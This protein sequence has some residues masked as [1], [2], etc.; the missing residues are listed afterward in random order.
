MA[1]RRDSEA[2]SSRDASERD[3]RWLVNRISRYVEKGINSEDGEVTVV[4]Q[5]MFERYYGEL[6][7]NEREGYSKYVS[8]EVFKAIEWGLP[9]LLRVF[10]GGVKAVEFKATGPDDVEQAK[11]ETDIVNHWF[12]DGSDEESGFMVLYSWLKDIMLYPNGYVRVRVEERDEDEVTELEGLTRDE[13]NA[14]REG[15]DEADI[16]PA[17]THDGRFDVTVRKTVKQRSIK[18]LPVAPDTAIIDHKHTKLNTDGARFVCIREQVTRSDLLT[19]GFTEDEL[20][21]CRQDSDPEFNSE[22]IIRLFYSDE[23][24]EQ[25]SESDI[26]SDDA[27]EYFWRH[28]CWMHVDWDDDGVSEL[29]H[30]TMIGSRILENEPTDYCELVAASAIHITHKHV[31]MSYAETVSDLQELMSTL[32]RQLLD[33]VYK[34]NVQ[35]LF[36]NENAILSD[37]STMDQLLDGTSEFVLFRGSPAESVMP[38]VVQPIV[39]EIAAVIDQFKEESQLRTG[40]APQ[41][42]LDPSVL[43]KSTMGAFIG[44]LEQASQRLE[45][46]ARLF[47]ETG[48]KQVFQKIHYCLRTYFK[49][50]QKVEVNGQ[51]ID[52]DPSKWRKRSNMTVNVGLGFNN[53]QAMVTLLTTLLQ[54]QKEALGEGLTDPTKI[55]HTLD[56]LIEQVNLGNVR[57]FF[58]DPGTPG[59]KPPPPKPDPAMIQAQATAESLKA[60]AKRRDKELDWKISKEKEDIDLRGAEMMQKIDELNQNYS[61]LLSTLALNDAKI[62]ELNAKAFKEGIAP[63]DPTSAD[64]YATAESLASRKPSKP[65]KGPKANG[66]TEPSGRG[67]SETSS[68]APSPAE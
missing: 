2:G 17:M 34:Q 8:R 59:W 38:E 37:N 42:S 47:A 20:D 43:E 63:E 15:E 55:F 64:E 25:D 4:R 40:V 51:W 44:A 10:T 27:E 46:L 30:I 23:D 35:R 36:I 68:A 52:I 54:I 14:L 19:E 62:Q 9:A 57:S 49:G 6:F 28:E 65:K 66:R 21:D 1:R 61:E 24:P 58:V 53:K 29:R 26:E 50:A 5:T 32:I 31:G 60:D 3:E 11:L 48:F 13:L 45:L 56:K 7:G 18:V 39:A 12:F 22:R 16:T 67:P 33:N 41:L